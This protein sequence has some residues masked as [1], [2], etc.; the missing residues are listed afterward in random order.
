MFI[1]I[2]LNSIHTVE[3]PQELMDLTDVKE[4]LIAQV[5]PVVSVYTLPGGQ[6]AYRGN[7]I[8]FPQDVQEFAARLPHDPKLLDLLIVRRYSDDRSNFRD[9]HV[10]REKVT[11]ALIWLKNNNKF[12]CD[13]V[14]DNEILETF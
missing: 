2:K 14:I 13:I 4:M 10:R 11:Q 9:F 3:V 12:Y 8:N 7:I 6:H 5:F 1:S